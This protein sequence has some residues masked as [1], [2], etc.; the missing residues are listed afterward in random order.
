MSTNQV[1]SAADILRESSGGPFLSAEE[2]EALHVSATAFYVVGVEPATDGRFGVQTLFFIRS[3]DAFGDA[4]RTLAFSHNA[5][6]E[7]LAEN[8]QKALAFGSQAVGPWYLGK[9]TTNAGN[10]AWDMLAT[11]PEQ[12][13]ATK[14][15]PPAS[16]PAAAN[17]PLADDDLPFHHEPF[18][19]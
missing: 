3:K 1:A 4:Q 10:A 16:T 5:F 18:V 2:K 9:F 15:A 17:A 19:V 6:R 11:P 14:S 7:R 8:I 12:R 13:T